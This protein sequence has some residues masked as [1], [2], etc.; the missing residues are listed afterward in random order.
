M[1]E[2]VKWVTG[3]LIAYPEAAGVIGGLLAS[4]AMT[5]WVKFLLPDTWPERTFKAVTRAIA[6]VSAFGFCYGLW[7]A[8]DYMRHDP[9]NERPLAVMVSIGCAF[10]SPILYTITMRVV[11]HF[12]PWVDAKISARPKQSSD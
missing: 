3:M 2:T 11:V 6:T 12:F 10:A 4:W 1:D 9:S 7:E 8:I 5:Q